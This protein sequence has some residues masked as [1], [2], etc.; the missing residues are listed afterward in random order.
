MCASVCVC[1]ILNIAAICFL[2]IYKS[3][4]N[5]GWYDDCS[6]PLTHYGLKKVNFKTKL[7][8]DNAKMQIVSFI[9]D[10]VTGALSI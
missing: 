8:D 2:F 7:L 3:L 6:D 10:I 5:K 9:L 4:P 1:V